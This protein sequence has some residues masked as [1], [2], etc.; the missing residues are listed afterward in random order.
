MPKCIPSYIVR[1]LQ[2]NFSIYDHR[3]GWLSSIIRQV[4]KLLL[5]SFNMSSGSKKATTFSLVTGWRNEN[6]CNELT[7]SKL[8]S[9]YLNVIKFVC[10]I[11]CSIT[12]YRYKSVSCI[13]IDT[14]LLDCMFVQLSHHSRNISN[15]NFP[16][17]VKIHSKKTKALTTRVLSVKA[18]LLPMSI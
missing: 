17:W 1:Y 5:S 16:R 11:V 9:N 13:A 6:G 14:A 2:D 18:I 12:S 15:R 3:I 8:H 10:S 4:S 7:S